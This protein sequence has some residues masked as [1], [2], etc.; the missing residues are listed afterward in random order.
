MED[1]IVKTL[2]VGLFGVVSFLL[3]LCKLTIGICAVSAI[4]TLPPVIA[5]ALAFGIHLLFG[6]GLTA[7]IIIFL[8][9]WWGL[10]IQ[11]MSALE[12]Y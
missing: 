7:G 12:D 10:H 5:A 3:I 2:M 9:S 4:V 8:L 11:F 6:W 1:N